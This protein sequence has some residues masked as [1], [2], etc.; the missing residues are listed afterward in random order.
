MFVVMVKILMASGTRYINKNNHTINERMIAKTE[1]QAISSCSSY[2]YTRMITTPHR[3][4]VT[5]TA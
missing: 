3:L 5:Q 4:I 2:V 1:Y